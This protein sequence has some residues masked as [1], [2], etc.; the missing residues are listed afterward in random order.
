MGMLMRLA[1]MLRMRMLVFAVLARVLVLVGVLMRVFVAVRLI[2]V[3][4][5]V[6]VRMRVIVRVLFFHNQI[7][8]LLFCQIAC[9]ASPRQFATHR[10]DAGFCRKTQDLAARIG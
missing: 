5:L 7:P 3:L 10:L 8:P 6:R 1:R 2:A 4:V 9:R